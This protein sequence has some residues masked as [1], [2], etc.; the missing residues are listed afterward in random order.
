MKRITLLGVALSI[1]FLG[2]SQNATLKN[3][4][5]VPAA[6]ANMAVPTRV[7]T[8]SEQLAEMSQQSSGTAVNAGASKKLKSSNS[9]LSNGQVTVGQTLYQLQTNSSVRDAVF[10]RTNG[11]VSAVWTYSQSASG[12]Y[13]D[14]GTGYVFYNGTSW[15]SSPSARIES[16]RT[17][18][19]SIAVTA[20]G[21]EVVVDHNTTAGQLDLVTRS[22]AGTGAWT[23]NTSKLTGPSL[24]G[25]LW[26]RMAVGGPDGNTLHVL[27]V[28]DPS[29][30]GGKKYNHQD[31][32]LTYSRS[33]DGGATW[34]KLNIVNA[35]HDSAAGFNSIPGDG[36][37][38][39]CR[40]NTVAYV[41]GSQTS[42]LVMVKSIDNGNTWTSKTIINF[43]IK[44]FHGQI[45]DA[46]NDGVADT[47]QSND[48]SY[49][50][51]IDKNNNV[52]VW[53]G[54]MR[55]LNNVDN[56][57]SKYFYFP[58]IAGLMYWNE[59][60]DTSVLMA[61]LIDYD[62]DG[63]F[64]LPAATSGNL[65][66]G[67]YGVS[68]DSHPSAG[69]DSKGNIFVTYDNVIENTDDGNLKAFRNLFITSSQ[70]GGATWRRAYRPDSD[71]FNE[72]VYASVAKNVGTCVSLIFQQDAIAGHGATTASPDYAANVGIVA[73]IIYNCVDVTD[74]G[75][76]GINE[77][78]SEA[79]SAN[80]YPN[81]FNGKTNIDITLKKSSM[82]VLDVFNTMGQKVLTTENKFMSAGTQTITLDASALRAGVYF[83]NLRTS[84]GSVT[85]KMII[86]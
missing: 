33:Q 2:N 48:G 70:D 14:R 74:I 76:T 67:N 46:N 1:A 12:G 41:T 55:V 4:P 15:S 52:H 32:A 80:N 21:E 30:S 49:A 25:N 29:F 6:I 42:S 37:A 71:D 58:G 59:V 38:I 63:K 22:T 69:M 77:V 26:P 5:K 10:K 47:L 51:L 9:T 18:W 35:A 28:T 60:A 11:N 13:S 75:V 23:E 57:S 39:D 16:S 78:T 20:T 83:Y 36:Y 17:G 68:L 40:G 43:P 3:Q 54:N 82:V 50:I 44:N 66:F 85:H 56:D 8:V 62:G 84:D 34:D 72:Q 81:P 24:G 86:Q 79:V 7:K 53:Y 45:T 65:A 27:S 31:P 19:P 64:N 73:D 61:G